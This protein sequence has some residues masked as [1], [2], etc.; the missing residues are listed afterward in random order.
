MVPISALSVVEP[1]ACAMASI[2]TV[3]LATS[4]RNLTVL[5]PTTAPL[6]V[7]VTVV[8]NALLAYEDGRTT[9]IAPYA[10]LLTADVFAAVTSP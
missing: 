1:P 10:S 6:N 8:V 4:P 5:V 9:V 3:T 2:V 7:M